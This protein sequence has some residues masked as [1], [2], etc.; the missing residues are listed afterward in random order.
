MSINGKAIS[1]RVEARCL[2]VRFP[3]PRR[4]KTEEERERRRNSPDRN[5]SVG[6][7]DNIFLT[8]TVFSVERYS[9]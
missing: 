3:S 2:R 7:K 1:R 8:V 4:M 5:R 6:Q 9:Q